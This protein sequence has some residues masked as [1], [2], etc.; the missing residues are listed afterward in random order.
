MLFRIAHQTHYRYSQPVYLVPHE[1]RLRPRCDW[2]Q[3]LVDFALDI[4]PEP[5]GIA[6]NLD[7]EGNATTRVWF[8]GRHPQLCV[9]LRTTVE[10]LRANPFEFLLEASFDELCAGYGAARTAVLAPYLLQRYASGPVVDLGREL[11]RQAGG[12]VL[13]FLL[14]LNAHVYNSH[15][16]EI[17]LEGGPLP[18][19]ET[20]VR[21]RGSCRDLTVLF[22]EVCRSMGLAARFVSGYQ[23]GDPDQQERHMHAWAEVYL[24]GAGWRG[25]DPSL[26]LAVA[27]AHVAVAAG[28]QA[29][30][31]QPLVGTFIRGEDVKSKLEVS[32]E[33]DATLTSDVIS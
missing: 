29:E 5:A 2:S 28:A 31:A 6:Y 17:R 3:R 20:L 25:Y 4:D 9:A 27:D 12:Q 30:A 18:A 11:A 10:T 32:I 26:G 16:S 23:A 7:A 22:M 21:G 19:E 15:R 8:E 14:G 13:P 24:P 1:I 33:L